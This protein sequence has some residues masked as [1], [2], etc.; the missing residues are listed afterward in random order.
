[1]SFE[2]TH[3]A[4]YQSANSHRLDIVRDNADLADKFP[5][6]V[7]FR[8]VFWRHGLANERTP[9]YYKAL[10]PHL[11]GSDVACIEEVWDQSRKEDGESTRRDYYNSNLLAAGAVKEG[12]LT[13]ADVSITATIIGANIAKEESRVPIFLPVDAYSKSLIESLPPEPGL[14]VNVVDFIHQN[15]TF[16]RARESLAIKQIHDYAM[17]QASKDREVKI[18]LVYGSAHTPLQIALQA[19][20]AQTERVFV[21]KLT[22]AM[23]PYLVAERRIRFGDTSV[24]EDQNVET[25]E[26]ITRGTAMAVTL[27]KSTHLK[28]NENGDNY[29]KMKNFNFASIVGMLFYRVLEN[30][31]DIKRKAETTKLIMQINSYNELSPVK[32]LRKTREARKTLIA[33]GSLAAEARIH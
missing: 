4:A 28:I 21:D 26:A 31:I 5:Q 6:N 20:G 15:A 8:F 13:D 7:S 25:L 33:L 22:Y 11:I 23:S 19:L 10:T 17:T 14:A 27:A 9:D 29:L 3:D 18:A 2:L 30:K 24:F 1:V 16:S 12:E 32:R